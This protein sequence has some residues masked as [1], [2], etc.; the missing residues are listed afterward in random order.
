MKLNLGWSKQKLGAYHHL[1]LPQ[2]CPKRPLRSVE[3]AW[4]RW[5]HHLP[6]ASGPLKTAADLRHWSAPQCEAVASKR[7]AAV[8]C[9]IVGMHLTT[10]TWQTKHDK[11]LNSQHMLFEALSYLCEIGLLTSLNSYALKRKFVRTNLNAGAMILTTLEPRVAW[12]L[13][14]VCKTWDY[15]PTTPHDT[16]FGENNTWHTRVRLWKQAVSMAI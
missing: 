3:I 15:H 7:E 5:F 16:C 8:H 1:K 4:F 10:K 2:V 6:S 12:P 9:Q 13:V 14:Q 11:A